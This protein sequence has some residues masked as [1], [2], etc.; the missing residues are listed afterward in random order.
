MRRLLLVDGHS[1]I[2]RSH[3]AF[4]RQPLRNSRGMNTSAVF[5]FASTLRKI[6][7]DMTPDCCAVVFDAPG[8]TFR[9]EKFAEYKAQR[10]PAPEEL[11]AQIPVIKEMVAAW[12]LATFEQPGYEA[13]DVLATIALKAAAAGFEVIIATSDKDLLQLVG[14]R[15]VI[16]DPWVEKRYRPADVV[17]KLGV[18]PEQVPDYLALTGDAIDN[19]P[20]VPGIGPKR[21]LAVLQRHGSLAAALERDERV[22]RHADLA[23]LSRELVE[24]RRQVPLALDLERLVPSS[25]DRERLRRVYEAMEFGGLLREM[26]SERV[27]DIAITA[28]G[29]SNDIT[30]AGRFSFQCADGQM[31]ASI[32]GKSA[33]DVTAAKAELLA[34]PG[35][36]KIGHDI[37]GQMRLMDVPVVGPLFDVGV[38]AWLMDPNR[39]RYGIEDC[40]L[41]VLNEAALFREPGPRAACAMRIY[42]AL[43]P[44]LAA[45][46]LTRVATDIE[47]P[48][49]PVLGAMER[50]GV[51]VDRQSL[52]GLEQELAAEQQR[53]QQD[54]WRLAGEEFNVA[55]PRQLGEVLFGRLR[56]A[57]GRRT[58]T[59][60]AT[61]SD[62]LA[63][64]APKHEIVRL[65]LRFRELGK[66][67]GTYLGPL[68][69]LADS[70]TQRV[71]ATLNQTGTSTGRL[72]ASNPNLQN[73]PIRTE[74]G[75]R[76][77][78][79]F[80]AE[81]GKRLVSADYS[82]IEMR[83]LAH[84]SG[85]ERL[86]QA[87][88]S[89]EDIH[90]AT[91]AA[92]LNLNPEAVTQ[93]QR[94]VAKMVNYGLVYG[95]GDY[96]L[97]WRMDM[98]V[99]EA[100]LFLDGYMERFSG[101]ARWREAVI[102]QARRDGFVRTISGRLRPVPGITEQN[103][104]VVEA[105][106]RAA[107]NAPVQGSAADII[108]LAMLRIEE[109]L[110]G[111]MI[112]QV[113][114]ELLL[115]VDEHRARETAEMVRVEMERAWQLD[116]PLVVEC[117]IGGD[118]S[119]AH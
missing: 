31:W 43:E 86:K 118:W 105:A 76:I 81:S 61:G 13:D 94:R 60:Y 9:D 23:R 11:P 39:K 2:Y 20:G 89:G 7:S 38:G 97:S 18:R 102:E 82:Q 69:A 72:S 55:S 57:R 27:P 99:E 3:F 17:A 5:G 112:L 110:P 32:D 95:M 109:L 54:I 26:M 28:Y 90:V 73:V 65:V 24:L 103:R 119:E 29:G 48:L 83:V 70:E 35:V 59:G 62:I 64:L 50:R 1:V 4:V 108:K 66:L 22:Q 101:V 104:V 84:L 51:K 8:R 53:L 10:P 46:G 114:D 92:I 100:R 41:M 77:R 47:M 96:G 68:V 93:D 80:V 15:I 37:K 12:G 36:L 19:V 56:L 21:A 33:V 107:L 91:A 111:T 106:R 6:L 116:V 42:Q 58:K 98:P 113:H 117:G 63:E 115:E 30:R 16:Y 40:A 14:D 78:R 88:A 85:D 49:I 71:H 45:M 67:C 75:R 87:F 79:A 34:T 44:Q 52:V 25:P 74:L